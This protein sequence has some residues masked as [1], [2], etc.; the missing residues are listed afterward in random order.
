MDQLM[1]CAPSEYTG[2]PGTCVCGRVVLCRG[3]F[4]ATGQDAQT[5]ASSGKAPGK[6]GKKKGADTQTR[7]KTEIHFLGGDSIDEVLFIDGWGDGAA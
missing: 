6:K 3:P 7:L 5:T 1:T 2:E 4:N